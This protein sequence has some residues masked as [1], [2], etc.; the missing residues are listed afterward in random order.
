MT[1][2]KLM[3][4]A[5]SFA[6]ALPASAVTILTDFSTLGTVYQ[7]AA[8]QFF[9]TAALGR[10]DVTATFEAD[11]GAAAA[12]L[13]SAIG[14]PFTT[15]I[16]ITLADLTSSSAVGDSS[17]TSTDN[18]TGLPT[19]SDIRVDD[20]SILFFA[21]STPLDN[22]EYNLHSATTTL[23]GS[24]VNISRLGNAVSGGPADGRWDL[25][26]LFVHEMEHSLGFSDGLQL[27]TDAVGPKSATDA[28]DRDLLV[29]TMLTGF[30]SDFTVPFVGLSAHIDGV[31][32]NG[33]FN[34]TVVAQPGFGDSQRALPTGLEIYGLCVIDGCTADQ[35]NPNPVTTVPEPST[36]TLMLAAAVSGL[37]LR[38]L[39][40]KFWT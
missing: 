16:N 23:G 10:T 22:A 40:V 18:V 24:A 35:V 7:D 19:S 27:F 5:A 12:Y 32:Q 15:T 31:V 29:S 39:R 30:L 1:Q 36:F 8:G 14:R 28:I 26:T 2:S 33:L 20:G 3:L 4:I 11:A 6:I 34:D 13:Q 9:T 38:R 17:I 25:V 37:G 21:D